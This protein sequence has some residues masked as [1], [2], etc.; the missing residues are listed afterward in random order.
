MG[1]GG[2]VIVKTKAN[3]VQFQLNFQLEL[4][5]AIYIEFLDIKQK[6][7]FIMRYT[8][9]TIKRRNHQ[10]LIQTDK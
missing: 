10:L 8:K 4:S 7:L 5:L 3:L 9:Y 1:A 6:T 2:G